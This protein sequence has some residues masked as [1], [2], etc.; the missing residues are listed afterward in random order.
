MKPHTDKDPLKLL[1]VLQEL[2]FQPSEAIPLSHRAFMDSVSGN[3]ASL[4]VTRKRWKKRT[5]RV[6]RRIPLKD[7]ICLSPGF[8]SL[9]SPAKCVPFQR[10]QEAEGELSTCLIP[11]NQRFILHLP[12]SFPSSTKHRP[13]L[14]NRKPQKGNFLCKMQTCFSKTQ[15]QPRVKP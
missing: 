11:G 10:H 9:A 5:T 6:S 14:K 13:E 7:F 3:E 1:S 8:H 12:L 4:A 15:N 2:P